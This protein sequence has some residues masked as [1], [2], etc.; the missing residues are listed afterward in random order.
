MILRAAPLAVPHRA[1][2]RGQS[3]NPAHGSDRAA[4]LLLIVARFHGLHRPRHREMFVSYMRHI[5]PAPAAISTEEPPSLPC[6][7]PPI[8]AKAIHSERSA[9]A[10]VPRRLSLWPAR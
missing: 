6:R 8:D 2:G 9:A 1:T 5:R 3:H 7:P 4:N 10:T